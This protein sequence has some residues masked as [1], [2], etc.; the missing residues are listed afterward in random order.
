MASHAFSTPA[1]DEGN[2][3]AFPTKRKRA[4]QNPIV[5]DLPEGV[6]RLDPPPYVPEF[7]VNLFMLFL[8]N[9][10]PDEAR[11]S[12]SQYIDR[13]LVENP[14]EKTAQAAEYWLRRVSWLNL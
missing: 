10:M 6:T 7:P 4:Y 12:V 11:L 13:Q 2:V 3:V 5:R 9:A 1:P 14:R 8:L